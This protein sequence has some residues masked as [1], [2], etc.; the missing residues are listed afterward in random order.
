[1]G[2]CGECVLGWTGHNAEW[3]SCTGAVDGGPTPT[4]SSQLLYLAKWEPAVDC[5][6]T[7]LCQQRVRRKAVSRCLSRTI[8]GQAA[9]A[10]GH[11]RR[12]TAQAQRRRLQDR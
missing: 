9:R 7:K 5:R 10:S 1:M 12:T 8:E 2:H 11:G 3:R 4:L 6:A